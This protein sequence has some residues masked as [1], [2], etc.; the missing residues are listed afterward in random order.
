[1]FFDVRTRSGRRHGQK[2]EF[3]CSV[4]LS[5]L[6]VWTSTLAS[7]IHK[8]HLPP[9]QLSAYV[10]LRTVQV[11]IGQ[12]SILICQGWFQKNPGQGGPLPAGNFGVAMKPVWKPGVDFWRFRFSSPFPYYDHMTSCDPEPILTN[13]YSLVPE[14][15]DEKNTQVIYRNRC[16]HEF[17]L[18]YMIY[19]Y[20]IWWFWLLRWGYIIRF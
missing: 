17:S 19:D 18:V 16:E 7:G 6:V 1:V 8:K 15:C 12:F 10:H 4:T 20:M 9:Q 13:T 5:V 2:L 14:Q 11:K 3:A